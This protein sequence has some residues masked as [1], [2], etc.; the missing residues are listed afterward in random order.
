M[1]KR[2]LKKLK[3]PLSQNATRINVDLLAPGAVQQTK[4][5]LRET[6]WPVLVLVWTIVALFIVSLIQT[7][8]ESVPGILRALSQE[9]K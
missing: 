3:R 6:A 5:T 7:I 4:P 1:S 2:K 9:I 8:L